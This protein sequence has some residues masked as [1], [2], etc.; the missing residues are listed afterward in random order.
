MRE[1]SKTFLYPALLL[2]ANVAP[3]Q[4]QPST[5][6]L[7]RGLRTRNANWTYDP[8]KHDGPNSNPSWNPWKYNPEKHDGPKGGVPSSSGQYMS[9]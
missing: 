8:K 2:A 5:N 1:F 9:A 7:R 4:A 6:S 3:G